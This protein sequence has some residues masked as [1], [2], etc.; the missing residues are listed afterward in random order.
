M[1]SF[2]IPPLGRRLI[3][4]EG[5]PEEAGRPPQAI[6]NRG[7]EAARVLKRLM[8]LAGDH[9]R[10]ATALGIELRTDDLRAVIAALRDHARGGTGLP[11][12]VARDEVHAHVL[13]RFFEELVEEPSN[14][15]FTTATGPDSIRYD[16]MDPG[17][18][19]ECLDLLEHTL[20]PIP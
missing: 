16:A 10:S 18:W 12:P 1:N 20:C 4:A 3:R 14:I 6:E 8:I 17:F 19:L 2:P 13:D 9:A 11:V 5:E 7:A 15:L